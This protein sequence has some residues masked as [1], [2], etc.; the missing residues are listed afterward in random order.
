MS[1]SGYIILQGE[2]TSLKP[3][4]IKEGE[5]FF[6]HAGTTDGLS[7]EKRDETV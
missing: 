3:L 2:P 4:Y 5:I 6:Q 7:N 1:S